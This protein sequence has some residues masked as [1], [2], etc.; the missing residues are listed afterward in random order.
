MDEVT[1][2]AH[3]L[4]IVVGI[5]MYI[6]GLIGNLLNICVFKI[7]CRSRKHGHEHNNHHNQTSNSPLY[8]LV[9]SYASF[10]QI[11][12]P[13]LTRIIFDGFQHPKTKD[14]VL[15]TC[16]L[17]Y[18]VLH[19]CDLISLTCICMATLDRYFISSREVRL[20]QLSTTIYRTKQIIIII[21]CL[22]GLHNIPLSI[23]FEVSEFGDCIISSRIYSYYYLCIIQIFLHGII[24]ICFLSIFGRLTYKQL[25]LIQQ[26]NIQ[27]NFNTDK[28]LSRMLL[29]LCI[30]ILI[31]SVPYCIQNIYSVIFHEYNV[32]L[33][34][35]TLLVYY[36]SSVL[37]F[38]NSVLSFYI[39]FLSTPNFRKQVKNILLCKVAILSLHNN[40]I[41]T[42][43]TVHNI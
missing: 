5:I 3:R 2:F 31:S 20:R 19:T 34:S 43:A 8:L 15:I 17:R 40:Q 12:Y 11:V 36:L 16:K 29:L 32:Q 39:F 35:Y 23:Y 1:V 28:Q 6:F 25:K 18:Y 21:I 14:N 4:I 33:L 26:T 38:I 37:F 7:W 9:S 10:I 13:L 24:P 22:I 41:R 30:A 27:I 42:T